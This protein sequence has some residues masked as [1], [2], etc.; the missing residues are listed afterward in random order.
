MEDPWSGSETE[1]IDSVE[2]NS[3]GI[4]ESGNSVTA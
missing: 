4:N 2:D 3:V 1:S